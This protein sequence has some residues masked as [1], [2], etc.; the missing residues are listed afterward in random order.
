MKDSYGK[1]YMNYGLFD[2]MNGMIRWLG[3]H[4]SDT[5]NLSRA[6]TIRPLV[7]P[8]AL[9]II[10]S[11]LC[12]FFSSFIP[13][14][15]I[16][17]TV[18]VLHLIFADQTKADKPALSITIFMLSFSFV[19]IGIFISSRLNAKCDTADCYICKVTGVSKD[20]SGDLDMTVRLEGG[21]L[22]MVRFDCEYDTFHPGDILKLYG[23]LREP[24]N[25]GNPGEFDYRE[26]LR[27]QGILYTIICK[28]YETIRKTGFST[29]M[30]GII[31][32]FIFNLR[33]LFFDSVSSSFDE[34]EKAL[35]AAVC[36]GDKSLISSD[37]KRFFKLSCCSHLLAV[38]GTH[39][40]GFLACLP[41]LLNILRIKRNKAFITHAALCVLIGCLTGWSESVTR[42]SIMSI[43]LF[44][45]RE[46]LSALSLASI[47]MVLA[48][49]FCPM[50]S[51]F[52]MSFCAVIAIKIYGDKISHYLIKLHLGE[53][54]ASLIS[55]PV[56]VWLGLLP[57]WSDISM[58]PD[59]GHLAVQISG[60]A[61]AGVSCAFF[62]PCVLLCRVL[63]FAA[64]YMSS[65]L[66]LSLRILY[67][68]VFF[69]ALIS[70]TDA[71]PVHLS[72][73]L[74]FI[75]GISVFFF[76]LPPCMFR[77]IML[78]PSIMILTLSIVLEAFAYFKNPVCTVVF[79]DVGQGD[80]C[81]VITP[82]K[83]CL[84]DGGTWEEGSNTV[85][86][87][88][89]YYGLSYVDYGIMS[90]WD[91]DHAGGIAALYEQRSIKTIYTSFIPAPDIKDKDVEEFFKSTKINESDYISAIEPLYSGDL[92]PLSDSVYIEVLYPSES[93]DGG[94]E[95]SL[96]LML[97][98]E[99]QKA[100]KILF[101]GD[102]GS[103]T[104]ARLIKDGIKLDCDILKVSHHGSKYSS[105]S[106]F[107]DACSPDIAVISVGAD[108]F[109]GHPAPSTLE[110]LEDCG[111]SVFRTDTEGAVIL[112]Y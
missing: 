35:T 56:S 8:A 65:P 23:K 78:K 25:A 66:L 80:C 97:H 46:W 57:F 77:R 47:V 48:D 105:S 21:A 100:T 96:V 85:S 74:L 40:A 14:L 87:L 91:I 45:D 59:L 41:M 44:A 3:S 10:C 12:Y 110:R 1:T 17:I 33:K 61:V 112:E 52:Q 49:P 104:E 72:G 101:T 103:E 16:S 39:F 54:T 68:I 75:L 9:M 7:L 111:C 99:D 11:V 71:K 102:I 50:S 94:N 70:E 93:K 6:H 55:I 79:A 58:R 92:I 5:A 98:I 89:D 107:I 15:V 95:S 42:A 4:V 18:F 13:S 34:S 83:T 63:P 90:H 2:I 76:M 53:K 109:Y 62:I 20:L 29:G 43:C 86:N 38:S 73:T 60:T 108:N 84:I 67:R 37:V 19:Y 30:I 88:L 28:K 26:Y 51:G 32:D 106:E 36:L 22:C 82:D 24:D 81:L 27:K 31:R 69:G 64:E